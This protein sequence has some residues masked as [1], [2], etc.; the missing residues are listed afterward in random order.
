MHAYHIVLRLKAASVD[1]PKTAFADEIL[2]AEVL[3]GFG[4]LTVR[5]NLSAD[6]ALSKLSY[7]ITYILYLALICMHARMLV[8]CN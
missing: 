6:V 3:G 5:E 2:R 1:P 7:L 4:Q 8:K